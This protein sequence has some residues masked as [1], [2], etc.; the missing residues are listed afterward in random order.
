MQGAG[1]HE[2]EPGKWTRVIGWENPVL[3]GHQTVPFTLTQHLRILR[4]SAAGSSFCFQVMLNSLPR[5][6]C[7][8]NHIH[9]SRL[10]RRTL[11]GKPGQ[12][13]QQTIHVLG[14]NSTWL[15]ANWLARSHT[16]CA[17][18]CHVRARCL[19]LIDYHRSGL[20]SDIHS[21]TGAPRNRTDTIQVHMNIQSS[22]RC[23]LE[24]VQQ[25]ESALLGGTSSWIL[26][27]PQHTFFSSSA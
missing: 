4:Q 13:L 22:G 26:L 23:Y 8:A 18:V 5:C 21:L 6:S 3:N 7:C 27:Q 17:N 20:H 16:A 14:M 9:L 2:R 10:L 24:H 1:Q 15:L 12:S 25:F 11:R 19:S